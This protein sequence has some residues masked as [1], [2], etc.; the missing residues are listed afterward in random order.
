MTS[1]ATPDPYAEPLVFGQRMQILRTR[2][3]MSRTVL[4]GLLGK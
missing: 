2:R 4:A 3:G 1:D